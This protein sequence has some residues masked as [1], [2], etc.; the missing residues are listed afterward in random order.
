MITRIKTGGS[1]KGAGL[2]YLHDKGTLDTAE[3]VAWTHTVNTLHDDPEKALTEMRW[4]AYEQDYLKQLSG[5]KLSGRA[6]EKPVMTVALSWAKDQEPSQAHMVSTGKEF[7]HFMGWQ[8]HQ[9]LF[10]AHDDTEHPHMHI[11]L[12]RIHHETGMTLDDSFSRDRSQQWA[13]R[14]EREMGRVYCENREARYGEQRSIPSEGLHRGEWELWQ[15]IR[16]EATRDPESQKFLEAQERTLLKDQQRE[17]REG[18]WRETSTQVKEVRRGIWKEL[19][20]VE[21]Q[22]GWDS[23]DAERKERVAQERLHSLETGRAIRYLL[24][25]SRGA[26][27][28]GIERLREAQKERWQ[29]LLADMDAK[30]LDLIER[31]DFIREAQDAASQELRSDRRDAYRDLLAQQKEERQALR[32]AQDRGERSYHVLDRLPEAPA[33][34]SDPPQ[35]GAAT[36]RPDSP[37]APGT[38]GFEK[39][40]ADGQRHAE[41]AQ[42]L[43][44]EFRQAAQE[45][46]SPEPTG[47]RALDRAIRL[48]NEEAR[49]RELRESRATNDAWATHRQADS[50]QEK[51]GEEVTDRALE[52]A[53]RRANAEHRARGD[54]EEPYEKTI[55]R[56]RRRGDDEDA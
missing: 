45:S 3:R 39:Y 24:K 4:T 17:E 32:E 52:R 43:E 34:S 51:F 36:I 42:K 33:P 13:L 15:S 21:L 53:V 10:V 56:V 12:N 46:T 35:P 50:S 27:T 9:A 54:H 16:Q 18:F 28:E 7:L 49:E 29:T 22:E 19:G 30:R 5:N 6:T 41:A 26:E 1:F 48:A 38:A 40:F 11:V 44:P 55:S 31:K 14:Y 2:Y 37:V 47:D 20:G 25:A 8:D 23:L